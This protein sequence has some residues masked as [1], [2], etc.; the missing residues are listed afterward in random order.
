MAIDAHQRGTRQRNSKRRRRYAFIQRCAHA[1]A[2]Q[3]ADQTH[4]RVQAKGREEIGHPAELIYFLSDLSIA[5]NSFC[6]AVTVFA[7]PVN[8]KKTSPSG[9][10]TIAPS[11]RQ[12]AFGPLDCPIICPPPLNAPLTST[13]V[14]CTPL[15]VST[16]FIRSP[17]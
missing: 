17:S 15:I 16:F 7:G 13:V 6:A 8:L 1:G 9:P 2:N 10:S 5:W 14:T 12:P 11:S 3:R 4:S